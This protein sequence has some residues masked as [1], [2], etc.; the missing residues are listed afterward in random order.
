M[1]N[2]N[3]F[4]VL[5]KC[6]SEKAN[7]E[8]LA[9]LITRLSQCSPQGAMVSP[10]NHITERAPNTDN[11]PKL[12]D[13]QIHCLLLGSQTRYQGVKNSKILNIFLK[14]LSCGQSK[15]TLV[16]SYPVSSATG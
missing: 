10:S 5:Y 15:L 11:T 9:R 7:R 2:G 13:A 3:S 6:V 12:K 8:A 14:T 1:A 16:N 4:S